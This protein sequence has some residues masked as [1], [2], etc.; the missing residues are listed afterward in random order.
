MNWSICLGGNIREE[1][2]AFIFPN[3]I[4]EFVIP[5]VKLPI[6]NRTPFAYMYPFAG[7]IDPFVCKGVSKDDILRE[8][9]PDRCNAGFLAFGFEKVVIL[10]R[11]AIQQALAAGFGI[12]GEKFYA[13]YAGDGKDGVLFVLE[14]SILLCFD[15]GLAD[16]EFATEDFDKEVAVSTGGFQETG[17]KPLRLRFYKVQHGIDLPGIGKNFPV[18]GHPVPGLDLGVHSA[19]S[20]AQ[21][22]LFD[23]TSWRQKERRE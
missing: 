16:G 1:T 13:V 18:S 5:P 20:C 4:R 6:A 19:L 3:E 12:V 21:A 8:D 15:S 14:L 23:E 7:A 11:E 22:D 10:L 2:V 9:V 17:V